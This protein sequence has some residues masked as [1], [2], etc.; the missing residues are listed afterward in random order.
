MSTGTPDWT[1]VRHALQAALA[2]V[3][4]PPAEDALLQELGQFERQNRFPILAAGLDRAVAAAAGVDRGRRT[5]S[6]DDDRAEVP[7]P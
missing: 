5:K 1:R 2:D 4:W 6:G 3:A 7:R